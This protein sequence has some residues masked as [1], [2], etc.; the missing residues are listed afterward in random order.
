MICVALEECQRRRLTA[1]HGGEE[2]EANVVDPNHERDPFPWADPTCRS[3]RAQREGRGAKATR[4]IDIMTVCSRVVKRLLKKNAAAGKQLVH[5]P[6]GG[7]DLR[8]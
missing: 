4:P 6:P 8:L 5:A 2:M 1:S 3:G 7:S